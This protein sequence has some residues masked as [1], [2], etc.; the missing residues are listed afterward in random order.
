[1]PVT[2]I[3]PHCSVDEPARNMDSVT[4]RAVDPRWLTSRCSRTN[5]DGI[6]TALVGEIAQS[7]VIELRQPR[8]C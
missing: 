3:P 7:A 5:N 4:K 8:L 6:R 2:I 1:M